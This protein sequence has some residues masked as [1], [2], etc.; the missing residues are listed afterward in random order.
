MFDWRLA[1][2]CRNERA[3]GR[4]CVAGADGCIGEGN[5]YS[6]CNRNGD[7]L[8]YGYTD[9]VAHGH[10]NPRTCSYGHINPRTCSYGHH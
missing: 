2:P 3:S 6:G 1:K 10:G 9:I 5:T 4:D 7:G 8:V